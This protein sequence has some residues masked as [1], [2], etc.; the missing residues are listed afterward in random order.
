MN[1][2]IELQKWFAGHCNGDWEHGAGI[3]IT[4]LDNPG[5]GVD[6]SLEGTELENKPFGF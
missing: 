1:A 4:T 3:T 2:L 5:W 6:I